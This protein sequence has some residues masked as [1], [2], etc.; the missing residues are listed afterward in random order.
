[1]M[2]KKMFFIILLIFL[3]ISM[4]V[5]NA[6]ET[7]N[8]NTDASIEQTDHLVIS[9]VLFDEIYDIDLSEGHYRASVEILL[10]WEADTSTFLEKFGDE[11]IHGHKL[12]VS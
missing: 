8:K 12:N 11:I 4:N 5:T 3:N 2:F 7:G 1:M 9:D 6:S 10:S